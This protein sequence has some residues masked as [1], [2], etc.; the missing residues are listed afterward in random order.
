MEQ[1][2]VYI[3]DYG[4]KE[5]ACEVD[6]LGAME[7]LRCAFNLEGG[8]ITYICGLTCL[9]ANLSA[10]NY[11]FVQFKRKPSKLLLCYLLRVSDCFVFR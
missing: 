11:K 6:R 1:V 9:E 10:N 8:S 7:N 5:F 3:D 2:K 4:F